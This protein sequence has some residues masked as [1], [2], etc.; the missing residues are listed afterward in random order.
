MYPENVSFRAG[1]KCRMVGDLGEDALVERL[2]K[3]LRL[4]PGVI[5]GPGD[6]CAVV[7][8][9]GG[10]LLLKVDSVHE[11]VHFLRS[12]PAR[13]VGWKAMARPLSDIAAMAGVPRYALVAIAVPPDL[14][15]S[16]LDGIYAGMGRA[17]DAF[18]FT[19]AGGETS[20]SPGGIFISV[21]LVGEAP[22][23][24]FAS[25]GGA[26]CGDEIWVTGRLGGSF[27]SGRHLRFVPRL[28]EAAWLVRHA[29]PTA[30]MDLSDGLG[31]DLPRL[32]L[33]SGLGFVLEE[34]RIPCAKGCTPAAAIGDGE[35]YELLVTIPPEVSRKLPQKWKSAF[36]ETPLTRI[37]TMQADAPRECK[38]PGYQHF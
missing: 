18:S 16:Y 34:D 37:G 29:R 3:K 30:M 25:R 10:P 20:R 7:R 5:L 2:V 11:G 17:A 13:A 27:E 31:A 22:H 8:Q 23:G 9:A 36:P 32:A 38:V 1:R 14:P 24:M 6:D 4:D 26:C 15:L 19:L 28:R 21:T 12:H 33:R 35:D